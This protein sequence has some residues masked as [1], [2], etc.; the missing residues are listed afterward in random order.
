MAKGLALLRGGYAVEA[1]FCFEEIVEFY[2]RNVSALSWMGLALARAKGDIRTS[3]NLCIETIQKGIFRA[4]Y[5]KNLAEAYILMENKSKTVQVLR[6]G[7]CIDKHSRQLVEALREFGTRE[8]QALP[9][10][11]RSNPVNKYIGIAKFK[12]NTRADH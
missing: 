11:S 1:V 7:L 5:Y 4:D 12:L 6:K 3:E 9:F 8:K 2:E 10:L